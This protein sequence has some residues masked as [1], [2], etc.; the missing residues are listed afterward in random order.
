MVSGTNSVSVM[1]ARHVRALPI[2]KVVDNPQWQEVRESLVGNWVHNHEKNVEIL[3]AYLEKGSK[4]PFVLRRLLNVLTG[5][6]H[7]AG[8]T[9]GQAA[10][11][12]LRLEVRQR[13][14]TMLGLPMG[15]ERG[16]I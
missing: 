4:D 10:T 1:V 16:P 3:R 13:W 15:D 5:S 11:D 2:Q 8:Y 6:V 9:K 7:R 12:A 14:N